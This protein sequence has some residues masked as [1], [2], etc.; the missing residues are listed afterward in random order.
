M[1]LPIDHPYK[2]VIPLN[3]SVIN[4]R[5][6]IDERPPWTPA[7]ISTVA[8]FDA[9]HTSTITKDETQSVS[10][11][12]DKSGNGNHATQGTGS[13]QPIYI[14]TDPRMNNLP[15]IFSTNSGQTGLKT[16]DV[17]IRNMYTVIYYGD[18]TEETFPL[19]RTLLYDGSRTI[20]HMGVSGRE[21]WNFVF[22]DTY[23]D[24]TTTPDRYNILPMNAQLWKFTRSTDL[25][26]SLGLGIGD[27]SRSW[28]GGYSEFVFTDGSEDL[29]TQ[30]K[31]EGY[32]SWKW[33]L[34][35][36]LPDGHPYKT[37][38]SLFGYEKITLLE[39]DFEAPVVSGYSEGSVPTGWTG[40]DS[41]FGS[42]WHG[43]NEI[44]SGDWAA[45][46]QPGNAQVYSFKYTNS[47][48]AS[49]EGTIDKIE[50]TRKVRYKLTVGI[51][52][53]KA[54]NPTRPGTASGSFDIRLCAVP[55]GHDYTD[56]TSTA[57]D[58]GP[59]ELAS[60]KSDTLGEVPDDDELHRFT[61]VYE[62]DPVADAAKAGYDIVVA[63][64][65]A[66]SSAVIDNVKVERIT[67]IGS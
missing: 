32:L 57:A 65:G 6:Q 21:E 42:L 56:F 3:L 53:D 31:I 19:W 55:P 1:S 23:R 48:L 29:A 14:P 22:E 25:L 45:T 39:E 43:L 10:Q 67:E 7:E 27:S 20:K 47:G 52:Y 63:I 28:G 51:G 46:S 40:A 13:N 34:E 16:Q 61:T 2:N 36:K 9:N 58:W 44:S 38:G 4:S 30:Q 33:G 59:Y 41:G 50:V 18:G 49:S 37:D 54:Q 26:M 15:A 62:T 60:L 66:T 35:G 8:W 5:L 11:W 64:D 12:D 17:T 24:G